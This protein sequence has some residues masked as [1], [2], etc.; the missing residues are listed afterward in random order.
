MSRRVTLPTD[1]DVT[2][3]LHTLLADAAA[4]SVRPTVLSLAR[5]FGLSN[6]T[7]WRHFPDTARQIRAVANPEMAPPDIAAGDPAGS[8]TTHSDTAHLRVVLSRDNQRL[9]EQLELASA[10]IARLTLTNQRLV[11][12]LET[13]TRVTPLFPAQPP[14]T[15]SSD[16]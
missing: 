12:A 1:D 14:S 9:R 2:A 3:A 4:H 7:F 5:R 15:T 6:S 11:E 8:A 13:A 10:Q 16:A